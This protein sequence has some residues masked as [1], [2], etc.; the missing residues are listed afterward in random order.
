MPLWVIDFS[1]WPDR[2]KFGRCHLPRIGAGL[3]QS[4][5]AGPSEDRPAGACVPSVFGEKT[6]SDHAGGSGDA[7]GVHAFLC[8]GAQTVMGIVLQDFVECE[9]MISVLD[10][11]V[12]HK[13]GKPSTRRSMGIRVHRFIFSMGL[14]SSLNVQAKHTRRSIAKRFTRTSEESEPDCNRTNQSVIS[15]SRDM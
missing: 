2:E 7:V 5:E 15:V 14:I 11:S 8:E 13:L 9:E 10:G 1:N 3:Y 4:G 6:G 12:V